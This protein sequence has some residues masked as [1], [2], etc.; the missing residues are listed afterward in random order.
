MHLKACCVKTRKLFGNKAIYSFVASP[1][2]YVV[3]SRFEHYF[4]VTAE[5]QRNAE[6]RVWLWGYRDEVICLQKNVVVEGESRHSE[7]HLTS[8]EGLV[9][10]NND[11]VH[12]DAVC[13]SSSTSRW[14]NLDD[15]LPSLLAFKD[16][17]IYFSLDL[18]LEVSALDW[19]ELFLE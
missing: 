1:Y 4:N 7:L 12:K 2:T 5:W 3:I 16:F 10:N 9:C 17:Y 14:T 6:T 11:C 19:D 15:L 18:F 13:V 8:P